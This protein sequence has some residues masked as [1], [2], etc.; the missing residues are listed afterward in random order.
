MIEFHFFNFRTKR[1]A[2]SN[3]YLV[4]GSVEH[5]LVQHLLYQVQ[6]VCLLVSK[7]AGHQ[8]ENQPMV[9]FNPLRRDY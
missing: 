3:N 5:G 4:V 7:N 2:R 6:V 9:N 1:Q 8:A